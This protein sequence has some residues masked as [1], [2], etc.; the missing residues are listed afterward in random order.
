MYFM[1]D[2]GMD[3]MEDIEVVIS[4]WK[5]LLNSLFDLEYFFKDML[6]IEDDYFLY[7]VRKRKYCE[8]WYI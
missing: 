5:Y 8:S 6:L 7:E 1:E 2:D 3:Y 4:K